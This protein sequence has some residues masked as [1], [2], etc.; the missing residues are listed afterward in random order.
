[1]PE[2]IWHWSGYAVALM[3]C[4]GVVW[5]LFWDRPRGQRRC[6][7]CWYDMSGASDAPVECPECGRAHAKPR[8]LTRTRRRWGRAAVLGLVMVVGGYGLWVVPRVQ[9]EGRWGLA[10][11]LGLFAASPWLGDA[12]F[13]RVSPS[14]GRLINADGLTTVVLDRADQVGPVTAWVSWHWLDLI[15]GGLSV[16][17]SKSIA[18]QLRMELL[19]GR[20]LPDGLTDEASIRLVDDLVRMS[21]CVQMVAWSQGMFPMDYMLS[22]IDPARWRLIYRP[23]DLLPDG[24]FLSFE[25]I[26]GATEWNWIAHDPLHGPDVEAGIVQDR[27]F[28]DGVPPDVLVCQLVDTQRGALAEWVV[29]YPPGAVERGRAFMDGAESGAIFGAFEELGTLNRELPVRIDFNRDAA[30]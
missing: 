8:H 4:V 23:V 16:W 12:E 28:R 29:A 10:P 3:A 6:R 14:G 7:R 1:M 21:S 18:N 2:W 25:T 24:L 15:E 27:G 17:S 26:D 5:A 20:R 9:D 22:G 30:R 11:T 19:T 13:A